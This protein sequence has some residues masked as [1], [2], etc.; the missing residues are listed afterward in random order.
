LGTGEAVR[1][2]G[3]RRT[4]APWNAQGCGTQACAGAGEVLQPLASENRPHPCNSR[5][6]GPPKNPFP[7]SRVRHP[8]LQ[9]RQRRASSGWRRREVPPLRV[10]KKRRRSGRDDSEGK[11]AGLKTRAYKGGGGGRVR[12]GDGERS[13]HCASAKSADAPVGMTARRK[14]RVGRPA[15]ALL[16]FI[17]GSRAGES[18]GCL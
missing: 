8:P 13:L 18:T 14:G 17:R 15:S 12:D 16:Y 11:R 1:F 5:K 4:P 10:G 3:M 6:D 2:V 7:S 9:R